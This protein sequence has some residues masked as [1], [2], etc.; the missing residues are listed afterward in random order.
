LLVDT[1]REAV[2]LARRLLATKKSWRLQMRRRRSWLLVPPH[3]ALFKSPWGCLVKKGFSL[4]VWVSTIPCRLAGLVGDGS[5]RGV[6]SVGWP[7][8]L[9]RNSAWT[10]APHGKVE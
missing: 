9:V 8:S 2:G 3:S 1:L 7:P 4:S 5:L 6:L 10:F